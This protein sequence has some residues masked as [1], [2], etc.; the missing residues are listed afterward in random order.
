MK[1]YIT[2]FAILLV[3]LVLTQTVYGDVKIKSPN[4]ERAKLGTHDF[5]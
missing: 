3:G 4:D 1:N 2:R 5:H